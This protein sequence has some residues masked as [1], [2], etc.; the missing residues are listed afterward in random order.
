MK[1][2]RKGQ[3]PKEEFTSQNPLI[4]G[5]AWRENLV[6]S[7]HLN[8]GIVSFAMGARN[9]LHT[10]TSDQILYVTHGKGIVATQKEEVVVSEGDTVLIPAGEKHW[11]GATKD[12]EFAH[13]VIMK[14]GGTTAPA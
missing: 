14:S 6:D 11:H 8:F 12:T 2:V 10:H 5:E 13:A 4:I 9:K 1:V 7:E 3:G